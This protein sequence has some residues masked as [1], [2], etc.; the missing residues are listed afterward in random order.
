MRDYII[1]L[2]FFPSKLLM[3]EYA[4]SLVFHFIIKGVDKKCFSRLSSRLTKTP[5]SN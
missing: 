3:A 1:V 2:I 5:S 4:F